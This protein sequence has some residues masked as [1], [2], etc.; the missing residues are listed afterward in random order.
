MAAISV[1]ELIAKKEAIEAKKNETV[2]F[3]TSIGTVTVK[4]PTKSIV[5]ESIEQEKTGDAY[6]ILNQVVEPNLKDPALQEAYGC[7][8]PLDIVEKIFMPGEVANLA[9]A[10]MR[11]SGYGV[12]VVEDLKN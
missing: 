4:K 6:L 12:D 9:R 8:E 5:L 3:V 11:T 2:D 7:V 10:I 1:K